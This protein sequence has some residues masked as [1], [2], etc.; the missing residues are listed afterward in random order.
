MTIPD[1]TRFLEESQKLLSAVYQELSALTD[2]S[3]DAF[4]PARTALIVVDLIN[5]FAYE[6]AL[7]S[8]RI[9]ALVPAV[10]ALTAACRDRGIP[11]VAFADAHTEDSV[12]LSSFPPH[13]LRGSGESRLCPAL[14]EAAERRATGEFTLI[15]KN[16]TNGFAE[17]VMEMWRQDNPQIG[18][19]LVVGDCTDLCVQHF[20]LAAKT[21]H[22]ARNLALRIVV[23]TMLVD[24]YDAPGHPADTM[25]AFS[26][27]SMRS[28]GV[29]LCRDIL[30]E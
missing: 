18:T 1:K 14:Q 17:P 23:P 25:N 30:V 7:S 29:E 5:G 10:A 11:V 2:L 27:L 12:E 8:P 19:Y 9:A 4:D 24:T 22:N 15:E 16:S 20:A 3:L 26:L 6:G 28:A 13:C 21:W